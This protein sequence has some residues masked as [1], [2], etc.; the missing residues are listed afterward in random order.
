[1]RDAW[2]APGATEASLVVSGRWVSGG[3]HSSSKMMVYG[4]NM[5]CLAGVRVA[6]QSTGAHP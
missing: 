1:M 3:R 4:C 5:M 6:L 2:E